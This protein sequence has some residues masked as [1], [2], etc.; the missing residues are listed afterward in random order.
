MI[1]ITAIDTTLALPLVL[2]ELVRQAAAVV[3]AV[4]VEEEARA[5]AVVVDTLTMVIRHAVELWVN[6]NRNVVV[7][8]VLPF[9]LLH[10]IN[11]PNHRPAANH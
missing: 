6:P 1:T 3:V 8:V 9:H 2:L 10:R 11:N 4:V 5:S 7:V